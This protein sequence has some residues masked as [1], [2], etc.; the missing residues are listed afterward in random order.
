[1]GNVREITWGKV[2][3]D[4]YLEH[5]GDARK[6][7]EQW[8]ERRGAAGLRLHLKYLCLQIH[9]TQL[10]PYHPEC[11]Q[12]LELSKIRLVTTWMGE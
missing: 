7:W 1:M 3:L 9:G 5:E 10:Q 2:Q 12:S 6:E 8:Q 4:D 11:S